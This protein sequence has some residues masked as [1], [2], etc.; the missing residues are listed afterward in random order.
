VQ[1]LVGFLGDHLVNLANSTPANCTL[2]SGEGTQAYFGWL[3]S[4][5]CAAPTGSSGCS[6]GT[7]PN[8][9]YRIIARHS[10]KAMDASGAQTTN[11]TQ[12]IQWGYG[13]GNNQ[14]WTVTNRGNNQ[15]SIIG[16]QSGRAVEV[17]GGATAN[18][19]RVQLWDWL[20]LAHQKFTF[21]ATS[22]GYYR[23]TPTHSGASGSCLDVS[24][25]SLNDGAVVHLWSYG[26]GNNQQWDFQ[27][28]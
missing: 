10:G 3:P 6:G 13:G 20:N 23:I 24:G 17:G 26:G 4:Y 14:R 16:V 27:A 18:G 19:S 5:A 1:F 25:V 7:I 22:G 8:G 2:G 12:I 9:T 21:T 11:R 15:Y 28:P